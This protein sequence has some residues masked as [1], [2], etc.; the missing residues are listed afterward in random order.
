MV[1]KQCL[2]LVLLVGR[3]LTFPRGGPELTTV[4]FTPEQDFSRDI[5]RRTQAM[6]S[7]GCRGRSWT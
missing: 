3:T 5:L 1:R 7:G 4:V 2:K 6:S